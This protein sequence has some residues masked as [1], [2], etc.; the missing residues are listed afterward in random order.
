MNRLLILL[1]VVAIVVLLDWYAFQTLKVATQNWAHAYRIAAIRIYWGITILAGGL[2]V[3][4]LVSRG[5]A[6]AQVDA[7]TRNIVATIFFGILLTKVLLALFSAISDV[8]RGVQ[9]AFEWVSAFMSA[10]AKTSEA[11]VSAT[12]ETTSN[13]ISRS[14]FLAKTGLLVSATPLVSMS[15]GI[16]SGAHDYQV[17]HKKIFLPNLPK[18]FH[19]IKIAQ[20]SDIHSGSFFNKT[21]VKGG[22]EMLL[23]EKPDVVLFTG[24]LVNNYAKEVEDYVPIFNKVKAP[25]GVFSTLGNHDYA[26]YVAWD[27]AAAKQQNL[28]DLMQAH[29]LM[30]WR[31]LNDE[32]LFL[33]QGGEKLAIIGV[34]NWGAKGNFPKY[35]NL[36]K[37]YQG[38]EEAATKILLSHDPSH[39]DGQVR[40]EF[41]DIDLMLA[42]HTHG[43]QFGV[44]TEF[45][46]WSP[47]QYMYKQWAGLYTEGS[48]HLYVNRGFGYI[49]FPGRIGILPEITILELC[50]A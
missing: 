46:K 29:K 43:M 26:D 44:E 28:N 40:K 24:D 15:Y 14:E 33:E 16:L 8:W 42:G 6:F 12:T 36:A 22:V 45:F 35:G 50:K 23:A 5:Q 13:A 18:A 17:H 1:F 11:E 47:V 25:M 2:F 30:G 4:I 9:F 34:Q 38:T 48:Q 39:W 37:A 20:L 21:A 32:H 49:G 10:P 27:S 19:G 31:L 3:L 41:K 7:I